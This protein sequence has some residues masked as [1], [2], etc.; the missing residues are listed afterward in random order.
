MVIQATLAMVGINSIPLQPSSYSNQL[1][2]RHCFA[3]VQSN[4]TQE[5]TQSQRISSFSGIF[6]FYKKA[7][8]KITALT[9]ITAL[10]KITTL[11]KLIT[12]TGGL[13]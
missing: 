4:N 10:I 1:R 2:S 7:L 3:L 13:A 6:I 5:Q 12:L 9:K 8:I 11:I